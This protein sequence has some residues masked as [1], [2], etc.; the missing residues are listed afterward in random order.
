MVIHPQKMVICPQ[1]EK[2]KEKDVI[3]QPYND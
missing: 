1:N 2:I 3:I